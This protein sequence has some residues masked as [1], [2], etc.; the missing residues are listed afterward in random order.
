MAGFNYEKNLPHQEHA[1]QAVLSVFDGATVEQ[2]AS[3]ENPL[4]NTD[5]CLTENIG[6]IQKINQIEVPF[7]NSN[8]L[9]IMMETGT[10]K[11]YT[12]TK[13]IFELHKQLGIFKFIVI[14]PTL[15]IK[16]GTQNF[17]QSDDL[18]KHFQLDF[19]GDY[20]NAEIEL[21]VV[22][23]QKKS[24]NKKHSTPTE[25]IRFI[26]AD[27]Q[28][29]IHILLINQGMVNSDTLAGTDKGN[30]GS[31]LIK[32]NFDKPIEALASIHPFIILDEPHK[33][34][35]DNKTWQNILKFSP[36][37]IIRYGATFPI[38]KN[39]KKIDYRN[40]LYRLTAIDAFNQDL[41]KGVKVFM[42]QVQGDD[43][44]KITLKGFE[45]KGKENQAIFELKSNSR[46]ETF[47]LE[48]GDSLNKIHPKID[49]L[50]IERINKDTAVIN[51]F[52]RKKGYVINPYCYSDSLADKM[53]RLAISEHFAL[54]KELLT[55]PNG[56]IKPLTLFFIDDIAGYRD[57]NKLAGSLKTKFEQFLT[58]EI[59]ERLATE[60][61]S[62]YKAHLQNTLDNLSLTHG[63]YFSQDNSDK[64]EKIEQEVFEILHDK[65][66]LLSLDNPRRFIF[67]KWTLREGWDNPNVFAICKLRSSGSETSK[68]QEVGR[69]LRLPVN[70]YGGRVKDGDFKLNYF[71][72]NTEKDFVEKLIADINQSQP[73]EV[74]YHE[75][76][77]ELI[78]KIITAY[79]NEKKLAV[80][81]NCN[82]Q[83]LIDDDLKFIQNDSLAQIKQRYPNAFANFNKLKDNKVAIANNK[84]SKVAMRVGKYSELQALWEK[85]NEKVILQY[86]IDNE[87][88]FLGL[89]VKYLQENKSKFTQTGIKTVKKSVKIQ[90]NHAQSIGDDSIYE[91]HFQPICE[92]SYS[93]FLQKLSQVAFIKIS[94][95]HKAFYQLQDE[96]NIDKFLNQQTI[97]A[98]KSGFNRFL[99]FHSF[100]DFK[101]QYNHIDSKVHPTKFTDSQGK[102][103][104]EISSSDL[105]IHADEHN[106]ALENYLF[107]SVFYDSDIERNN[108]VCDEI[109]EVTV[110]TKIPKNSIKIPV[111]GG[112]TYSPDFAYIVKKASGDVLNLIVESKGVDSSD[113]L[114]DEEKQKIKHAEK[115][116]QQFGEGLNIEFVSQFNQ[117]KIVELI[118]ECIKI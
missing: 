71:V 16:A 49:D 48:K 31:R 32:D 2:Q 103:L 69:G 22:E 81:M 102:P 41:V 70:E 65:Q 62:D 68:L 8:V 94:T 26:D 77:D 80:I 23:S 42:E 75:L 105:G 53:M 98:I 10:G 43:G 39:T 9:D 66:S 28:Q 17:L 37:F 112:G 97:N 15:S 1:V 45:K 64:D 47:Y 91:K 7:D 21:Y 36:Q 88:D 24:K 89:F 6:R 73:Q 63:G 74:I 55:R 78:D 87:E 61:D 92:M 27:N 101:I 50:I 116:F 60:T 109:R 108:I 4:I 118:K 117:D 76:S 84:K 33:F 14:V 83:N 35:S 59:K 113:I 96:I 111:A 67:S 11:T 79:P 86:H 46:K 72:D 25:I 99:L 20:S 114:R 5:N 54:E 13:T 115:L 100:T 106:T 40:L 3:G 18:K 19:V 57:G 51:G 93:E 34:K 29:K 85:I 44:T 12:Y 30:D 110:F 104:T 52:E 56:K 58:A 38:D 95:L 82:S 90:H 107:E